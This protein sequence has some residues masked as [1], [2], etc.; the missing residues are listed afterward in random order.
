MHISTGHQMHHRLQCP[1][2]AALC[3]SSFAKC[4][5]SQNTNKLR[6]FH[7][8]VAPLQAHIAIEASPDCFILKIS[9]LLLCISLDYKSRVKLRVISSNRTDHRTFATIKAEMY[10][11]I[12]YF[13]FTI[14]HCAFISYYEACSI[15]SM[16]SVTCFTKPSPSHRGRRVS[17]SLSV[18]KPNS[19]STPRVF[20]YSATLNLS[21]FS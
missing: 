12:L 9:G 15:S 7:A 21:S 1:A 18:P 3:L 10:S 14:K 17:L 19:P 20:S 5:S 6:E 8:V 4:L 2:M 16:K 13:L 11:G